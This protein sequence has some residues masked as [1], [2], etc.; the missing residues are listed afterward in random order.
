MQVLP[1]RHPVRITQTPCD[2]TDCEHNQPAPSFQAAQQCY[3]LNKDMHTG[4]IFR[5]LRHLLSCHVLQVSWP[6]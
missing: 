2:C 3:V 1:T 4:T 6:S 5:L